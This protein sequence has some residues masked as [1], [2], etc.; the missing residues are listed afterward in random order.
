MKQELIGKLINLDP[1]L[2]EQLR[3]FAYIN[4]VTQTQVVKDA[5]NFYFKTPKGEK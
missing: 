4:R 3:R 2:A 5:L 1:K